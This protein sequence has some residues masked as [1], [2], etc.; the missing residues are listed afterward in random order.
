MCGLSGYIGSSKA[1]PY[2][3]RVLLLDNETRGAHATG[4]ANLEGDVDKWAID[5]QSYMMYDDFNRIAES[6]MVL[7]H[8]RYSTMSNT[9][10]HDAAH[11]FKFDDGRI[12]GAHNGFLFNWKHQANRLGIKEKDVTVDSELFY[13]HLVNSKYNTDCFADIEGACALSW[14]DTKKNIFYLY[15]RSSRPL[16]LGEVDKGKLYYSSRENGLLMLGCRGTIELEENIVYGFKN[17]VLVSM[18]PVPTPR[19]SLPMD[20]TSSS[21]DYYMKDDDYKFLGMKK[22]TSYTPTY[23]SGSGVKGSYRYGYNHRAYNDPWADDYDVWAGSQP[24]RKKNIKKVSVSD[25]LGGKLE[26]LVSLSIN[27]FEP[28]LQYLVGAE[29]RDLDNKNNDPSQVVVSLSSSINGL[30]VPDAIVWAGNANEDCRKFL[31]TKDGV[32]AIPL[33]QSKLGRFF[34]VIVM[35]F[36]YNKMYYSRVLEINKGEIVEVSLSV[37]FLASDSHTLNKIEEKILSKYPSIKLKLY[38]ESNGILEDDKDP[39]EKYGY[40]EEDQD[41][42][43]GELQSELDELGWSKYYAEIRWTEEVEEDQDDEEFIEEKPSR[44]AGYI[45][46]LGVLSKQVFGDSVEICDE[47]FTRIIELDHETYNSYA[48]EYHSLKNVHSESGNLVAGQ[49]EAS[50]VYLRYLGNSTYDVIKRN[51]NIFDSKTYL[52]V[53]DIV[54]EAK[55]LLK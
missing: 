14:I 29:V 9:D 22:K 53:S 55:K 38:N 45:A 7:V 50:Y 47:D 18:K 35:P 23:V 20:V 33:P 21:A 37:P 28:D 30:P 11:P 3:L 2:A 25:V 16:F 39:A 8:N 49:I 5:P 51:T 43:I 19:I 12:I 24:E 48:Y 6:K 4:M 54:E 10:D 27:N 40:T 46:G 26:K 32:A 52:K 1:D 15:R 31:T 17:G 42:L 44:P 34:R 36:P 13:I 41:K